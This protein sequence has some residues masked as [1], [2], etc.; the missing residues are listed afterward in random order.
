M[1]DYLLILGVFLVVGIVMWIPHKIPTERVTFI[2][3][4]ALIV[5][6]L[7]TSL[8]APYYNEFGTLWPGEGLDF[9]LSLGNTFLTNAFL[10]VAAIGANYL[11]SAFLKDFQNQSPR[12]G[13]RVQVRGELKVFDSDES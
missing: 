10:I 2:S 1:F 3:G 7:V 8:M 11:A 4:L 6:G 13:G 12:R 9:N 5:I